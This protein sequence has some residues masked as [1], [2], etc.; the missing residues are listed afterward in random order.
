MP[1]LYQV[2]PGSSYLLYAGQSG[3]RF[4]LYALVFDHGNISIEKLSRYIRLRCG[5]SV[6]GEK[7]SANII[8]LWF[9]FSCKCGVEYSWLLVLLLVIGRL[10]SAH[11]DLAIGWLYLSSFLLS[12]LVHSVCWSKKAHVRID[13]VH[14]GLFP[15]KV[16]WVSNTMFHHNVNILSFSLADRSKKSCT[17]IGPLSLF[18]GF[19]VIFFYGSS[20]C[21]IYALLLIYGEEICLC[22]LL[23]GFLSAKDHDPGIL[24]LFCLLNLVSIYMKTCTISVWRLADWKPVMMRTF[25]LVLLVIGLR[26]LA[27]GLIFVLP[28]LLPFLDFLWIVSVS[29]LFVVKDRSNGTHMNWMVSF[30]DNCLVVW[31]CLESLTTWPTCFSIQILQEEVKQHNGP[32][33]FFLWFY[34]SKNLRLAHQQMIRLL[35]SRYSNPGILMTFLVFL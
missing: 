4:F 2:F 17:W 22:S 23:I 20:T 31:F 11:H 21:T 33:K 28:H 10:P 19:S 9:Q 29:F 24:L 26:K 1:D 12:G 13:L 32:L 7:L 35:G 25:C 27:Y 16:C 6:G 3:F 5:R 14:P 8:G 30:L 34:R 18:H 15:A